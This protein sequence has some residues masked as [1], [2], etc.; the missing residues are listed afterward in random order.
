MRWLVAGSY[1]VGEDGERSIDTGDVELLRGDVEN[2]GTRVRKTRG[3]REALSVDD[4]PVLD[5]VSDEFR[6]GMHAERLHHV[7]LCASTVQSDR[8]SAAPISFMRA[9]PK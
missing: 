8:S 4:Q 3:V 5:G 9:R 6:R 2:Y 7:A 1:E